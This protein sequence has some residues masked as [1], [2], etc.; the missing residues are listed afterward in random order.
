MNGSILFVIF[1]AL[2]IGYWVYLSFQEKKDKK[3]ADQKHAEAM[4][5]MKRTKYKLEGMRNRNTY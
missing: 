2:P 5:E 1:L 3:I 4:R